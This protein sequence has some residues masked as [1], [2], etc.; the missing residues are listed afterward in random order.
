MTRSSEPSAWARINPHR[1]HTVSCKHCGYYTLAL[2]R[3]EPHCPACG[4]SGGTYFQLSLEDA[5]KL[6][7]K[8]E[9]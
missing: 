8:H 4:F 2:E 6:V 7:G 3:T 1:P 9:A 5:M